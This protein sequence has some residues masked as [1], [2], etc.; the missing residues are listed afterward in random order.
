MLEKEL[1]DVQ[2]EPSAT[3]DDETPAPESEETLVGEESESETPKEEE[4]D[5]F[6]NLQ[7]EMDRKLEKQQREFL[8]SQERLMEKMLEKFSESSYRSSKPSTL[9]EMSLAQL[10]SLRAEAAGLENVDPNTLKSIDD[11]IVNRRVQD[12]VDARLGSFT[13]EQ[14]ANMERDAAKAEALQKYPDLRNPQSEFYQKV[15]RYLQVRGEAYVK[16]NP[17]AVLDAAARIA[18]EEGIQPARAAVP[19]VAR[20][21]TA[22]KLDHEAEPDMENI[23]AL[24]KIYK[25]RDG[26]PYTD[27]ELKK[28]AKRKE[29][30]K[31][32]KF[33]TAF[34]K[35]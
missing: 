35:L 12:T 15:D 27:E 8:A 29:A 5:R 26:R 18:V 19:N 32:G 21:R 30:Y 34:D 11:A 9:E 6:H 24:A 10:Q 1:K 23:K 2:V 22:P 7:R 4:K 14:R 13:K 16:S 20:S 33:L 17:Q 31:N 25:H 3:P 28:I